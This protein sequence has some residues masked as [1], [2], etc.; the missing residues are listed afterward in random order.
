MNYKPVIILLLAAI[1]LLGAHMVS[2]RPDYLESFDQ[3]YGT[4]GTRLD[5]C[6]TCHDGESR[7]PYGKA[8]AASGKNFTEIENLDSDGD[9]FS[10]LVEIKALT[11]PGNPDDYPQHISETPSVTIVNA[12]EPLVSGTKQPVTEVPVSNTTEEQ[13]VTEVP[14]SNATPEQTATETPGTTTEEEQ[15]S[16]FKVI[17]V[18]VGLLAVV[19]LKRRIIRK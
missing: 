19:C 18:V 13:V 14:V 10:N 7:N 9:G 8:Y 3:H 12:T 17:P 15:T 1:V 4:G 2:A 11:F 16:G 6:I 5:S